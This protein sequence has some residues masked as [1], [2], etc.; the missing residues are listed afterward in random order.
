MY[1]PPLQPSTTSAAGYQYPCRALC[2]YLIDDDNAWLTFI[3]IPNNPDP[4]TGEAV[5][6]LLWK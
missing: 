5:H 2:S 3:I 4:E 6:C 1:L